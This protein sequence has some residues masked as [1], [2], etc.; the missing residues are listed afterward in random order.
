MRSRD[1]QTCL[2]QFHG[3]R[4]RAVM[5]P[6]R[7]VQG[8]VALAFILLGTA[9]IDGASAAGAS[10]DGGGA[11]AGSEPPRIERGDPPAQAVPPARE[12]ERAPDGRSEPNDEEG[13]QM[14]E[15]GGCPYYQRPLE[16]IV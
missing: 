14:P 5:P 12:D 7:W 3:A 2:L 11:G 13:R 8:L 9:A 4:L 10:P 16:R 15:G 1:V 6:R